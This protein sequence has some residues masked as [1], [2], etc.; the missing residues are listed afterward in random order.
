MRRLDAG[1]RMGDKFA[2][3]R[4]MLERAG[5]KINLGNVMQMW[6]FGRFSSTPHRVINR[7]GGDR[8]SIPF[9]ANPD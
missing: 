8:Y 9:F 1:S 6:S 3:E 5:V 4:L 2:G 7:S